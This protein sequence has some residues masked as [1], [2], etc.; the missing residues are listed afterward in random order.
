MNPAQFIEK[1][2]AL[3]PDKQAEV[4]DFIEFLASRSTAKLT[5]KESL[6]ARLLTIPNAGLDE[7]FERVDDSDEVDDVF[8]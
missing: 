1:M 3:P 5:T 2:Q 8:T 6:A 7:D 4:L